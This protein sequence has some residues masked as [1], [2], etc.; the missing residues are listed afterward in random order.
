[1]VVNRVYASAIF[2]GSIGLICWST[3]CSPQTSVQTRSLVFGYS[4]YQGA[5]YRS[6]GGFVLLM[7]PSGWTVV[8][9]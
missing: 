9:R 6:D 1:M 4:S 3:S 7:F 8:S 2:L 5:R